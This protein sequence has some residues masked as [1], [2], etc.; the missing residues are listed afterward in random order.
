[1][2]FMNIDYDWKMACRDEIQSTLTG[3]M[4]LPMT[5]RIAARLPAFLV[6]KDLDLTVERLFFLILDKYFMMIIL[7]LFQCHFITCNRS[8]CSYRTGT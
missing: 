6:S 5:M 8:S 3:D 4:L 7:Y 1:M 2:V